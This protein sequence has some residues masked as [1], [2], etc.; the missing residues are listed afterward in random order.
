MDS[1]DLFAASIGFVIGGAL[2]WVFKNAMISL[3]QKIVTWWKGAESYA[4]VL[5]TKAKALLTK[6]QAIKAAATTAVKS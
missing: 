1:A 5:E 4:A 3:W 2:I 6:A